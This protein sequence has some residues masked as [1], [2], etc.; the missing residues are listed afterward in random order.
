M[1][2]HTLR[3]RT[4]LGIDQPTTTRGTRIMT[5][6]RRKA[7]LVSAALL[8]GTLLM[9]ACSQGDTADDNSSGKTDTAATADTSA[10]TSASPSASGSGSGS[11]S[12]SGGGSSGT[13]GS[14]STSGGGK[15]SSGG[16]AGSGS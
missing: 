13:S 16:A 14:G 12:T 3:N 1:V 2:E 15:T 4:H 6:N 11:G 10:S 9:T 5:R 7:F 8:G